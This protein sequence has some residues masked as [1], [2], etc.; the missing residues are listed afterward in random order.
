MNCPFVLIHPECVRDQKSWHTGQGRFNGTI[1]SAFEEM[2]LRKW[3]KGALKKDPFR[4]R[5]I[6]TGCKR[7]GALDLFSGMESFLVIYSTAGWLLITFGHSK[8][9]RANTDICSFWLAQIPN[10][11]ELAGLIPP[12]AP[13]PKLYSLTAFEFNI[14]KIPPLKTFLLNW[15]T[16]TF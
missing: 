8:V 5:M 15:K 6:F 7:T 14:H 2:T 16:L 9:I 13:F 4:T 10:L 12:W 1:F 11:W 3:W